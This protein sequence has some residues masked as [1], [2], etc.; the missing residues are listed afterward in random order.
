MLLPFVILNG[1]NWLILV[2]SDTLPFEL[3]VTIFFFNSTVGFIAV[4]FAVNFLY[5]LIAP[6]YE[7][8]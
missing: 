4:E 8:A 1:P 2:S 6:L 7:L 3:Y 5:E